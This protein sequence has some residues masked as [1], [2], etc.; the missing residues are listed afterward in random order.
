MP[1]NFH[2]ARIAQGPY[3][4]M[5]DELTASL[6]AS[7]EDLGHGC[8]VEVNG[9]SP[10]RVN[11]LV[12]STIFAARD[13]QLAR[14][15]AGQPYILYQIEQLD[16]RG[17]LLPGWPEYRDVMTGASHIWDYAP[18]SSAYLRERGFPRVATLPPGYHPCLET[19][20]PAPQPDI[21]VLFY[22]SSRPRR[23]RIL[24]GLKRAGLRVVRLEH[25]YG[26]QRDRMIA[27]ARIVLNIH[28]WDG[29]DALETVRLSFLL[30]NRCFVVS[31]KSD[32]DPYGGGVVFAA[33]DELI[34]TCLHYLRRAPERRLA[35]AERG[36]QA[37][38]ARSMADS[39]RPIVGTA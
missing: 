36:Y 8:T 13:M 26:G 22:G 23:D 10:G 5:Y 27:R 39:L 4:R 6:A 16:D 11:I 32:H 31:E 34:D 9:L 14:H 20:R 18:A 19:F 24:D 38:K 37:L 1:A 21:D 7:L 17:G 29:I 25:V 35:I 28:G 3:L 2:I 33:Y 15:L 30:A 12:G